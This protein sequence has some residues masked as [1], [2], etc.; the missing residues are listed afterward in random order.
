MNELFYRST[1]V[2]SKESNAAVLQDPWEITYGPDDSLWITEAKGYRVRK[3]HPVNGGRRTILNLR[4]E[5]GA[6]ATTE[7]RR[8]FSDGQSPWPQGGMMGLAIHP[9][10]NHP[11]T[12][13]KYVYI[14]YV[15]NYVGNNQTYNGEYI[16]G[17]L[18]WTW[19]VRFQYQNGQLVSPVKIC[20]T[21]RGSN[22]HNSGRMII[23]PVNGVN[24]LFY[25]EGDMGGGQFD[26]H[27]R[28]NKAQWK[29]SYEGK[30]SSLQS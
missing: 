28:V 13:K 4:N 18:F 24:Y 8:T 19:I 15:R 20:D 6:F 2:P 26:N 25:A 22:D 17:R 5:S 27:N 30:N 12:P 3:V 23:A 16:S 14:A 11:T 9:D 7:Y 29:N 1:L 21:I 10:Y